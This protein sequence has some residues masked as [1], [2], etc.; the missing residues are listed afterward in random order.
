MTSVKNHTKRS[1]L[2]TY[3]IIFV[4]IFLN[5]S[6]EKELSAWQLSI[7]GRVG[8]QAPDFTLPDLNGQP[9]HLHDIVAAHDVTVLYFYFSA[10]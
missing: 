10:Y 6:F 4:A 9:Q 7:G 8:Q 3:L 2:L 5:H 1:T